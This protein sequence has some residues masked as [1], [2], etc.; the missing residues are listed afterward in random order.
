MKNILGKLS[1]LLFCLCLMGMSASALPYKGAK[2]TSKP[3][4]KA[5]GVESCRKAQGSAELSIN[6]VRV[7]INQGGNMWTDG[8]TAQYYVPKAGSSTALFCSALWI[9]GM[10]ENDQLRV[11]AMRF[12][13][14]GQDFWPGPLTVDNNASTNRAV[15]DQWDKLFRITKAEV[16]E[17]VSHY[18]TGDHRDYITTAIREWPGNGDESLGQSRF[19]A[20]F[21][22]RDGD[23]IYNPDNGDYPYY[24]FNG[25]LCPTTIRDSLPVGVAYTP[26]PTY[27]ST[28]SDIYQTGGVM[29]AYNGLL[30]DQVLK[31]DETLWWVFNDKGNAHTESNSQYAIGLEIRAQ[32]FAFTMNNEINDM[33]FYSYEIVNRS[34]FKLKDTYFSQWVDPDLG[35]AFDDYVGCDVERGL[36]YCYNGDANDGPGQGAYSGNPPAVGIDF[37]QGPYMDAKYGKDIPKVD[38]AALKNMPGGEAILAS[39]QAIIDAEIAAGNLKADIN[40][41]LTA[42]ADKY[43]EA[44]FPENGN[45]DFACAING[46]NFGNG[47]AN[48]ER[49]GM[50]RFIYYNNSSADNGEPTKAQHYYN[51]LRGIWKNNQYMYYGGNGFTTYD[52]HASGEGVRADFMFPGDSD[53]WG[54]GTPDDR[55]Y[56]KTHSW[57]ESTADNGSPNPP[58]DRRFMQ[59]AGPFTLSPGAINY[60]TVGIPF[61]QAATGGPLASVDLLRKID[62]KCQALFDNCFNVLEGPD[63][64]DIVV[65]ELDR[66]IILYLTNESGNNV[67]ESFKVLDVSIPNDSVDGKLPDRYYTFEGYQIFQLKDATVS[68]SDIYDNS[69]AQLVAQC[70]IQ[71]NIST[72]VN[73]TTD[74]AGNL[75]SQVMVTGAN[76]GIKHTFRVTEDL[77]S[78]STDK[79]LV[80]NKK[81]YFVAVA[82][83]QNVYK[84][85]SPTDATKIDGQKEPYLASR[86][87]GDGSS[88]E[89]VVAIPHKLSAQQNGTTVR[90][91]YGVSPE[92]T[93]VEGYGNGGLVINLQKSSIA[94]LMGAT[95]VEPATE[96]VTIR[97]PY[98]KNDTTIVRPINI[99]KEPEYQTNAGPLNVKV[100]DPL[101]V[102]P[103]SYY[104][105]FVPAETTDT[106]VTP[107]AAVRDS[108]MSNANWV[109]TTTDGSPLYDDVY[110]IESDRPLSE[111]NEQIIFG[112]GISIS[113]SNSDNIASETNTIA[114]K[115]Y[116]KEFLSEVRAN[117]L[118]SGS[119]LSSAIVYS[120]ANRSWLTGFADDDASEAT[121]WI[122]SGTVYD[123][124]NNPDDP[125]YDYYCKIPDT[126]RGDDGVTIISIGSKFVA[127]DP[128]NEYE[129][130]VN[131]TWAPYR[132]ASTSEQ[133]PAFCRSHYVNPNNSLDVT[134]RDK[135][136]TAIYC[137]SL[138]FNDMN[139]L[140]SVDIV[141]TSDKS[142]WTRCP[143]LEMGTDTTLTQGGAKKFQL[144][145]ERSWEKDGTYNP[146]DSGMSWFPGYAINLET[147]ERLNMMFGENSSLGQLN[148]RDMMWN[149]PAAGSFG[150]MHYVYVIGTG[151]HYCVNVNG[152]TAPTQLE[153]FSFPAYDEG[154][155]AKAYLRHLNDCVDI[156]SN[157]GIYHLVQAEKLFSSIMWV[158][159]PAASG[160]FAYGNANPDIVPYSQ[161]SPELI[162]TDA[163]VQIRVRKPYFA[164]W[165]HSGINNSE[166]PINDNFPLYRFGIASDMM[167]QTNVGY[168]NSSSVLDAI[169]VVPNPYYASSLY[170]GDQ[171]NNTVKI[172]NLPPECYITIYSIDGTVIRKL[173]G[174]SKSITPGSGSAQTYVEWDL[175]NERGLQISGGIYLIHVKADGIGETLVKWFGA[176]RPVDLNSFQ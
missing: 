50:R 134:N 149:P 169:T 31:G 5:D 90:T 97:D 131:G 8:A 83:A 155:T 153:M 163:T 138:L 101:N 25:D 173:R 11:A 88:V 93:R 161:R 84:Q 65:Q 73:Y 92:I 174:P 91:T 125:T 30:V 49:F 37:F 95:G 42:D 100:V 59:S 17:F 96:Q 87:K 35:Y 47:I 126:V 77:F 44:W 99:L 109:L 142:K 151:K 127:L 74:E 14:D 133:H 43:K 41:L 60:I 53:I 3:T 139:N 79:R 156:S 81:Y 85:Y 128:L 176:L 27:E 2:K 67:N 168:S 1:L 82:Y 114:I 76:Q 135:A 105:R 72:L 46:V 162:P 61:A 120:D 89:S 167:A 152:A 103:G 66:E 62:D 7:R 23:G 158:G 26:T 4:R 175:K 147:G 28:N 130:C 13:S 141:F 150:G 154:V 117:V 10:D 123:E 115:N 9:G 124:N 33:T 118:I 54:W 113:L 45:E 157:D 145:R 56:G 6:N 21:F 64:P 159:A 78:T 104:L 57:S 48:D 111:D 75:E 40:I 110:Q 136:N 69:K 132:L 20:P 16:Q 137:N 121:N 164:N 68:V 38:T 86:K 140:A 144:R 52:G 106:T 112:L 172:T 36:G 148:G 166:N 80:N 119:L 160:V 55:A 129:K 143:V 34:A 15:C 39:Y 58:G 122:R 171:V 116:S 146:A 32:A 24:D 12:G 71:N 29:K 70:D 108:N 102:K 22:D 18:A 107:N 51:Y 94:E 19:L 170:E 165:S 63:A 98:T